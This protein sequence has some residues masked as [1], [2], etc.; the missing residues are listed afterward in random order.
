MVNDQKKKKSHD[1][2][3]YDNCYF[4]SFEYRWVFNELF[5]STGFTFPLNGLFYFSSLSA[6]QL[7]FLIKVKK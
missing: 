1:K 3:S 4:S 7:S 2:K 6:M 5:C